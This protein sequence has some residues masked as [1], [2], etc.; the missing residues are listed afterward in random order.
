MNATRDDFTHLA[1]RLVILDGRADVGQREEGQG[2]NERGAT[3]QQVKGRVPVE[4]A[5]ERQPERNAEDGGE[6]KS[7][8]D[9]THRAT[10]A[11]GRDDIADHGGDERAGDAAEGA[12]DEPGD[13]QSG[14]GGREGAGESGE[15]EAGVN[16]DERA[17]AVD[18]VEKKTAGETAESGGEPVSR[19]EVGELRGRKSKSTH[20]LRPQRQ[21]DHEIEDM[22][23]LHG[24][25]RDQGRQ[26]APRGERVVFDESG[27]CGHKRGRV[28][29]FA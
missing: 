11:G 9:V 12:G 29:R 2:Q 19:D 4:P 20:Q 28:G 8:H 24:G 14:V 16:D 22:R 21:H 15:T 3:G 6:R 26:L 7:G 17:L 18:A 13:Q 10:P 1:D 27:G 23:E 25:Q 5:G